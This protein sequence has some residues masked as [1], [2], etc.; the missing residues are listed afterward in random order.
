[1]SRSASTRR[2]KLDH[3][4][5]CLKEDVEYQRKGTWLEHVEL[6]HQAA[7]EVAYA[8]VDISTRFLGRRLNAPFLIAAMT[9]G[10]KE[11]GKLNRALAQVAAEKGIG[12]AL[13]SQRP[14]LEDDSA[15]ESFS[16]REVAPEILLL[17]NIGMAQAL[18]LSAADVRS[19][20]KRIGADGVNLHLNTAMEM[21]QAEGDK[22]AG[23]AYAAIG[24]L[25][26]ALGERLVV[27]ETGC[28]ISRETAVELIRRGVKTIDV[29]GAG[30]TSWV[31]VEALRRGGAPAGLEEF[32]EWG[33][34]TA[35]SLLEMSGLKARVIASG[36]LRTGLDLARSIA[37]GAHLGT[38]ALPAL[39][40]LE[41]R[42]KAA[43]GDWVDAI[44][45][46][47]RTAMVLTGCRTLKDLQRA[48]RV[49]A[50]PLLEWASQRG[51]RR[52]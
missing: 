48:P 27:K 38:A 40:V 3:L 44:T 32:E 8:D 4:R 41:S 24:R 36:G 51:L 10:P 37:L 45:V 50:G 19:L 49:L 2:R 20:M 47:L 12:L 13:G 6:V 21:F 35:A 16:V 18:S 1:M 30:G 52:K 33:I 43:L 23:K 39:R 22:P 9:G 31:R 26:R 29:A 46:G 25:A 42:G 5:L 11:T 17:G 34:P 28:G 7:P 15:T 14:M